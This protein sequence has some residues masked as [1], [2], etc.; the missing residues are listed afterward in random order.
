MLTFNK[1]YLANAAQ[2]FANYI[3]KAWWWSIGRRA[4]LLLRRS[5]FES[6][7]ILHIISKIVFEKNE[8]KQKEAGV[9]PFFN[10]SNLTIHCDGTERPSRF[11]Y[12]LQIN[13]DHKS[14]AESDLQTHPGQSRTR[15]TNLPRMDKKK[16]EV[17]LRERERERERMRKRKG[18]QCCKPIS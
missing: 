16:I 14:C 2:K 10:P 6:R 7:W 15:T 1:A 9:G 5:E 8:N 13:N 3:T 17:R 4:R 12:S 18:V 11:C